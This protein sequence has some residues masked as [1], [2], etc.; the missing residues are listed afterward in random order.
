MLELWSAFVQFVAAASQLAAVLVSQFLVCALPLFALMWALF[1]VDWRKM[2]PTLKEGAAI[3]LVMI[4]FLIGGAW[5]GISPSSCSCL[6]LTI[7]NFLWQTAIVFLAFGVF[8][9]CGWLQA[10]AGW[11]PPEYELHPAPAHG[12]DDH[13]HH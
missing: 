9:F 7:P 1:A 13:G 11:F 2:W 10:R 5:G 6:G 4:C 8:L 3:P 12:H